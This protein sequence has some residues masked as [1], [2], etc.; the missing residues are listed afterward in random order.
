MW[1]VADAAAAVMQFNALPRE[2]KN[3]RV[4]ILFTVQ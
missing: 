2:K 3:M 4:V 1:R